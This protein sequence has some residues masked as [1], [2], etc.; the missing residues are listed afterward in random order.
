EFSGC[1]LSAGNSF[2]DG[3]V[4]SWLRI[5]ASTDESEINECNSAICRGAQSL[6]YRWS[7]IARNSLG[8][9]PAQCGNCMFGCRVGGK[10]SAATTYLLDAIRSGAR[11]VAPFTVTKLVESRGK[12]TGVEGNYADPQ[13]ER[14]QVRIVA[15]RVVLA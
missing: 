6:G 5:G 14:R 8:C 1:S 10:Q 13:G 9:N 3:L 11:V 15:P 12:V 4:A 2:M 7:V